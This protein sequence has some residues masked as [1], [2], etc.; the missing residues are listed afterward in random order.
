MLA[1]VYVGEMNQQRKF[2]DKIIQVVLCL[3][4]I[5][6]SSITHTPYTHR[7][8]H[9]FYVN[10]NSEYSLSGI[11]LFMYTHTVVFEGQLFIK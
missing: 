7:T 8:S 6:T 10:I 4:L 9:Y 5:E 11:Y 2:S 1:Q 3:I